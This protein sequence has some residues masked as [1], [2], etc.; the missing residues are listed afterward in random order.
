[1]KSSEILR[2]GREMAKSNGLTLKVDNKNCING[3]KSYK[4]IYRESGLTK[5]ECMTLESAYDSLC[6]L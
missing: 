3:R 1:M 6:G 2:H 5:W 4:V